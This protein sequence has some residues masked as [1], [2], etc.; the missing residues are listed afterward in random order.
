MY[1]KHILAIHHNQ[2]FIVIIIDGTFLVVMATAIVLSY[3]YNFC[4]Y[5]QY[6]YRLI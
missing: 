5:L 2:S 3:K 6:Q 4:G 1:W